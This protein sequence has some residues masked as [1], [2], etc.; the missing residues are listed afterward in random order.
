MHRKLSAS[1]RAVPTVLFNQDCIKITYIK[2]FTTLY[3][4]ILIDK[5]NFFSFTGNSIN[6][7]FKGTESTT[8]TSIRNNF[9]G[10]KRFTFPG[11]TLFI[12]N[13]VGFRRVS[14]LPVTLLNDFLEVE[15]PA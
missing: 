7:T 5:M 15:E 4:G 13:D 12:T 14:S 11:S 3:T 2:T 6:R 8:G 10:Y 9:K 1:H